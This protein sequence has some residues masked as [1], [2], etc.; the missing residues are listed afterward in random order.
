MRDCVPTCLFNSTRLIKPPLTPVA[1]LFETPNLLLMFTTIDIDIHPGR[2]RPCF[3]NKACCYA[4]LLNCAMKLSTI[5]RQTSFTCA[6]E[7]KVLFSHPASCPSK[8]V[9]KMRVVDF[10]PTSCTKSKLYMK[11]P[12]TVVRRMILSGCVVSSH[13]GAFI[14]DVRRLPVAGITMHTNARVYSLCVT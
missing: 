3:N 5:S 1:S 13:D 9:R 4:Y 2:F 7:T 6:C 10:A 14:V 11:V 8:P 12:K